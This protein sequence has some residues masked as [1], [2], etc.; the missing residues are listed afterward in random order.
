[1]ANNYFDFLSSSAPAEEKPA[2]SNN[3]NS[4]NVTVRVDADAF[5]LCDGEYLEIQLP[6]GKMEKVQLPAGQHLLQFMSV[7]YPDVIAEKEVDFP[8]AGKSYLVIIKELKALVDVEDEKAQKVAAEAK[9]KAEEEKAKQ[10]QIAEEGR[11]YTVNFIDKYFESSYN[12]SIKTDV[13][14]NI[15][16]KDEIE[17]DIIPA[18]NL[19]IHEAELVYAKFLMEGIGVSKD[20]DA[21]LKYLQK[22]AEG[23]QAAAQY[24]LYNYF[25]KQS[26]DIKFQFPFDE[27]KGRERKKLDE[28]ATKWLTRAANNNYV[29]AYGSLAFTLHS[30]GDIPASVPW[31]IKAAERND[32]EF[33]YGT[34]AICRLRLANFYYFGQGVNRDYNKAIYWSKSLLDREESPILDELTELT[35]Y[36]I[37][38]NCYRLGLGVEKDTCEAVKWVYEGMKLHERLNSPN[39]AN[40][41]QVKIVSS[42]GSHGTYIGKVDAIGNPHGY[43]YVVFQNGDLFKGEYENGKR[44]GYGKMEYIDGRTY[45]GTYIDDQIK[46]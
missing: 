17:R 41:Q 29:P 2:P 9:R 33:D 12:C 1:M 18:I 30:Q 46:N 23:G 34:G 38:A 35:A 10:A 25:T 20:E 15:M 36:N 31:Y 42:D 40:V 24:E 26:I 43:G 13:R 37:L 8:D 4:V 16:I 22:A 6:A 39:E 3:S 28:E 14:N 27:E 21:A 5:L 45:E 11:L 44:N 7:E 19:K 32:G